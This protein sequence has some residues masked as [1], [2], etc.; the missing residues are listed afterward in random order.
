MP[1]SSASAIK[2]PRL[3][4]WDQ[5]GLLRLTPF[6][7][8]FTDSAPTVFDGPGWL[9]QPGPKVLIE[10]SQ[11]S[12]LRLESL[13]GGQASLVHSHARSHGAGDRDLS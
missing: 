12:L 4:A 8:R 5:C 6:A 13:L 10:R 11:A 9:K 7:L 2:L 1:D 3:F